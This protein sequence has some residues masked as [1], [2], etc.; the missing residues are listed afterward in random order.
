[1][2]DNLD[3]LHISLGSCR[4]GKFKKGDIV[5]ISPDGYVH[6]IHEY[7]EEC[8]GEVIE[9]KNGILSVILY[10]E[11]KAQEYHPCYWLKSDRISFKEWQVEKKEIF[12]TYC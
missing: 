9:F 10:G 3:Y 4:Y 1:M 5:E 12:I 7:H 11:D 2:D 6:N 8:F